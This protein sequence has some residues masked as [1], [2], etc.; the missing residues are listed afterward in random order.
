MRLVGALLTC[1]FEGCTGEAR[2]C[3]SNFSCPASLAV[4]STASKHLH[5]DLARAIKALGQKKKCLIFLVFLGPKNR[6]SE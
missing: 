5:N 4:I 3:V 6:P 1:G 2:I